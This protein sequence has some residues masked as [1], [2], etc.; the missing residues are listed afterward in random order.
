MTR[1]LQ[2][3]AKILECAYDL[4]YR[5]GYQ[6]TT[7]D[8]VIGITGLSKPTVYKNFPSKEVLA[9]AY[10]NERK[11]R[12]MGQLREVLAAEK[13]P[14]ERF[15]GIMRFIRDAIP[16]GNFRGCGFFNMTAEIPDRSHP[17]TRVAL[18]FVNEFRGVIREVTE[19]VKQ[20]VPSCADIDVDEISEQY[21]VICCGAIMACQELHR[22][23][24]ADVAIA[25]IQRL[26]PAG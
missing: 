14:R 4:F 3:R 5:Q 26:L 12:E 23:A 11:A 7:V 24:P 17:V 10:L 18:S 1:A 22:I 9:V 16:E 21:Y 8:Q 19:D 20:S 25:Q 13:D 2:T 6:A 15:L